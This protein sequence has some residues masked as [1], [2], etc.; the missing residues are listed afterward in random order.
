MLYKKSAPADH[1]H[2]KH[3]QV[4][5][6]L[7]VA[8]LLL[9]VLGTFFVFLLQSPLQKKGVGETRNAASVSNGQVVV[10]GSFVPNTT[11]NSNTAQ[12]NL[13][14]NTNGVQVNGVQLVFNVITSVTDT[15][16]VQ[17][18]PSSGLQAV[19]QEVQ[20]TSDG[21]LVSVIALPQSL[22]QSYSRT[23]PT[24]FLNLQFS[25]TQA[26]AF[27]I[28]FDQ[29]N[30]LSTIANSNP[31]QDTLNTLPTLNYNALTPGTTCIPRPACL[32][33][34]P[35]CTIAEP[36]G[37]FCPT[38]P[39]TCTPRPAC[40]DAHPA[41]KIREPIGGWCPA[42]SPSP[43]PSAS[44]SPTPTVSP[45]PT[46]SISPSP[47]PTVTP[48]ATPTPTPTASPYVTPT[49]TPVVSQCNAYCS[50][51]ANC[52]INQRC[53]YNQCRLVTNVSDVNC[54]TPPDNGLNRQCNQYCANT[55]ECASGF[56]C[57]YNQCRR[58]DNPDS[59]T[60]AVPGA[61]TVT[62]MA[63]SCN[64]ACTSNRDC[65]VNLR[66]YSGS[67]RLATNTSS[68]S[69][70]AATAATVSYLYSTND[71]KKGDE[72][73][74]PD[75]TPTPS[76]SSSASTASSVTDLFPLS[77]PKASATTDSGKTPTLFSDILSV[78][79][80][81]IAAKTENLP[82]PLPV[83]I[84]GA[85]ILLLILAILIFLLGG[86]KKKTP[87]T[88]MP[89]KPTSP[90]SPNSGGSSQ[91][92]EKTLEEKL[93]TLQQNQKS[94]QAASVQTPPVMGAPSAQTPTTST[95]IDRMKEKGVTTPMPNPTLGSSGSA[96]NDSSPMR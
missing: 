15:L 84:I 52:G 11:A 57:F 35:A 71:Q 74:L 25:P 50:S 36:I 7:S 63:Q 90:S 92:T 85:G 91:M 87:P 17:V 60:C 22:P 19:S 88:N 95:M 64:L 76:S 93:K 46:P 29:G 49:P 41:C 38:T 18:L 26:G 66:C 6:V 8:S 68:L 59:S 1:N 58:P 42:A 96:T 40:L 48:A 65:A 9:L 70:S 20:K 43:T 10:A 77:S 83:L 24:N 5:A 51:N 21:F 75:V 39:P 14:V 45:S 55:G 47:S 79:K 31:P 28:V 94:A 69:C 30:S 37:G 89:P 33:A 72:I 34:H 23:V 32:D 4:A 44:P 12:V 56:T 62:A 67:C 61:A 53:Y 13:S 2:K 81:Q 82:F 78:L 80:Q 3:N 73:P 86:R 27:K 16:E 54:A